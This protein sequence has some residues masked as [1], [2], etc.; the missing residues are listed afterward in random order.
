LGRLRRRHPGLSV[1]DIGGNLTEESET[2]E[3][4][5]CCF[6]MP[7]FKAIAKPGNSV[8]VVGKKV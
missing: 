4:K 7:F 3:K 2:L 8:F 5:N 6:L 1:S